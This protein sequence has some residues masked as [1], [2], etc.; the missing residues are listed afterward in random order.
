MEMISDQ[1]ML[2]S[3]RSM[4]RNNGNTFSENHRGRQS[5]ANLRNMVTRRIRPKFMNAFRRRRRKEPTRPM[6]R[7][8]TYEIYQEEI[9][10]E[11]GQDDVSIFKNISP[12][13]K[14]GQKTHNPKIFRRRGRETRRETR[15]TRG[16]VRR[17]T[18]QEKDD[19]RFRTFITTTAST[20][21]ATMTKKKIKGGVSKSSLPSLLAMDKS[22]GRENLKEG[23]HYGKGYDSRPEIEMIKQQKR[24]LEVAEKIDKAKSSGDI[25][26]IFEDLLKFESQ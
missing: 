10:D 4:T 1:K 6:E 3:L 26:I 24:R 13:P 9:E 5:E 14:R 8:T 25:E 21:L 16:D 2:S 19:G 17:D 18:S 20:N 22:F 23:G 11:E 7:Y 15:E 12:E